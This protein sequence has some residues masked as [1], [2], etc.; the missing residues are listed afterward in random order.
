MLVVTF[1]TRSAAQWGAGPVSLDHK[2]GIGN[3]KVGHVRRTAALTLQ[4]SFSRLY[5]FIITSNS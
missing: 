2:K 3:C 1:C 4:L 5:I